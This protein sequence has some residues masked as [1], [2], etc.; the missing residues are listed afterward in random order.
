MAVLRRVC[1][2]AVGSALLLAGTACT[3]PA[4]GASRIPL[5]AHPA[6]S[7]TRQPAEDAGGACLLLS[8]EQVD[9][10]VG[11]NFAVSGAS[12]SGDT[13]TCVLR[14]VETELP[15][16]TLS[17]SPTLADP[18]VFTAS[19]A[20]KGATG[21]PDLGKAGYSRPLAASLTG[22]GPGAEVGWLSG[23]QRLMTLRYRTPP[24]TP[25]GDA[26]A[27]IPT[28]VALA[29]KIDQAGA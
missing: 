9:A 13:Y 25:A 23:N 17:V 26:T 3:G 2:I 27:L 20:P 22:A 24:G 7:P 4:A 16:L 8:F 29:K 15:D 11:G 5:S 14:R 6:P 19:V 18:G 12:S 28:L 21:V 1:G 10:T